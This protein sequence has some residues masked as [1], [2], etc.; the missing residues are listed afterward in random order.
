MTVLSIVKRELNSYFTS[1]IMY[2]VLAVFLIISGYFFYTNLVMYVLFAGSGVSIDLWEYMFND[3]SYMLLLLLPLVTMRL[4]AEEK[5]LGTIELLF[6][7]PLRDADI[8]FG[9]Y[10][11][12]LLVLALMLLLTA[13]YPLLFARIHFLDVP[14]LLTGYAGLFLLG[15]CFLACGILIS[16]LTEN[17]IVAALSNGRAVDSVLVY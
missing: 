5:K 2:V 14:I 9:K 4:F 16:S 6:T 3:I 1:F 10:L 17:Q 11:A 12:S 7:C 8:L 13:L 15:A